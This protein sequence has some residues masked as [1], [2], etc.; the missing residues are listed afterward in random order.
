MLGGRIPMRAGQAAI[1]LATM[2]HRAAVWGARELFD[3]SRF[4][5]ETA[6]RTRS[7]AD[8][9]YPSGPWLVPPA[10]PTA[11]VGRPRSSTPAGREPAGAG[12]RAGHPS[13]GW[14]RLLCGRWPH[15]QPYRQFHPTNVCRSATSKRQLGLASAV[16]WTYE[17]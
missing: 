13:Q 3:P 7:G 9:A 4:D 16:N 14:V 8:G 5:P 17:W 6:A 15:S 11:P 10:A 2:L 1:V 12:G